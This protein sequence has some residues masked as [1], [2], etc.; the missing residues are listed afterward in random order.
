MSLRF[1]VLASGLAA[2]AAVTQYDPPGA[3]VAL[4][5]LEKALGNIIKSPNLSKDQLAQAKKVSADVEKTVAELESVEG[6]KLSKEARAAKVTAAI[7][8]LQAMQ[9]DWQKIGD[10]KV[11]AQKDKLEKQ[12]KAKQ[13]ELAKDM[14]MLKVLNLEKAL[15]EKKLT[16]QKLIDSKNKQ[17]AAEAQK[18]AE[19]EA[20]AQAE[21]VAN[22]LKVAKTLK[23]DA[24]PAD[25][26]LK[27]ALKFLEGRVKTVSDQLAVADAEEKKREDQVKALSEQKVPVKDA[28]DPMA[29]SQGILK[30]LMKKEHRAYLKATAG[31]KG[32][33][34]ELNEAVASIKKGDAAA[35]TKVMTHMQAEMK[36]AQAK[37][38]KFLY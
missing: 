31:L 18:E 24:K 11:A 30:M 2:C 29:K 16:L 25:D 33:L 17:K 34:K 8:E 37:S 12:M 3:G 27:G 5:A 19:K 10:A 7:Q 20:A 9:S 36:T 15:A 32:E 21:E 6:K 1:L 23:A 22:V 28:N 26:K 14:K 4:D 35:L 38:H 13:A